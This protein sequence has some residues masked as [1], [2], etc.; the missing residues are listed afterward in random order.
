L[1][2]HNHNVSHAAEALEVSRPQLYN[3]MK[4]LGLKSI[5]E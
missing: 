5:D 2:I 1:T 3:L 4:K